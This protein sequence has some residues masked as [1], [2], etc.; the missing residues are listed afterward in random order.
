MSERASERVSKRERFAL[1]NRR[2][3]FTS[4]YH[5][6]GKSIYFPQRTP[7]VRGCHGLHFAR[8]RAPAHG[9]HRGR[10]GRQ[11]AAWLSL[12]RAAEPF[13]GQARGS[14][15]AEAGAAQNERTAVPLK[16]LKLGPSFG[17]L[18]RSEEESSYQKKDHSPGAEAYLR[19]MRQASHSPMKQPHECTHAHVR[20]SALLTLGLCGHAGLV[21]LCWATAL[22]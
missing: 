13:P 4:W 22:W 21:R 7:M 12:S 18:K 3:W 14:K 16:W 2:P 17:W 5:L 10:R 15:R 20:T 8:P 11:I 1:R 19:D 6:P 9:R